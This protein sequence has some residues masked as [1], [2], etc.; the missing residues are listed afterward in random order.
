MLLGNE[1]YGS[2]LGDERLDERLYALAE[3][4]GQTPAKAFT[5]IGNKAEVESLYRFL[6]N[7]KTGIDEI[8]LPHYERTR[9]RATAAR[10]VIVAHDTT[11]FRFSG[12]RDGLTRIDRRDKGTGFLAHTSLVMSQDNHEPLGIIGFDPWVRKG[13]KTVTTRSKKLREPDRE[14]TRWL[15]AMREVDNRLGSEVLAIHVE[16]REGDIYEQ[17]VHAQQEGHHFVIRAAQNRR[18]EGAEGD[19]EYLWDALGDFEARASRNATLTRRVKDSPGHPKRNGRNA[20]L[21][22]SAGTVT[23]RRPRKEK[24]SLPE[25]L[26]INV[27]RVYE[28]KPPANVE[29]VEWVLL[30][31][32][33]IETKVDIELIVDSYRA[34]WQIEEYFKALKVGCQIERRQLKSLK[35]ILTALGLFIPI[36]WGLLS[37]RY[38]SRTDTHDPL[39]DKN[40]IELLAKLNKMRTIPEATSANFYKLIAALGGHWSSNG[41]A[42][43]QV[44]YRGYETFLLAKRIKAAL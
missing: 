23:L 42:G 10:R 31:T 30:T 12:E 28:P 25:A 21:K 17:L 41:P 29:P 36:A 11:E 20:K 16:D 2:D 39:F 35:T 14:S 18:L 22:I 8:V 7:A 3:L 5:A 32:E 6:R 43:W 4:L 27:V 26:T 9:E 40:D 37:L 1:F 34:R 33:P 24:A 38:R 19:P 44:L 13:K 15:R